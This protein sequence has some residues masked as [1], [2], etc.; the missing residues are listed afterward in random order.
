MLGN[1]LELVANFDA[2]GIID[3]IDVKLHV[4]GV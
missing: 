3:G 4:A 1:R 2:G